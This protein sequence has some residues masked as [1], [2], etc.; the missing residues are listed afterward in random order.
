MILNILL[1][2][3]IRLLFLGTVLIMNS[4]TKSMGQRNNDP[5]KHDTDSL[6]LLVKQCNID[7]CRFRIL[8]DYFWR[9]ANYDVSRARIAGEWAFRVIKDSEN[10]P[11]LADGYDI[12]GFLFEQ[13]KKIDSAMIV[14]HKALDLSI[15]SGYTSRIRWCYYHLGLNHSAAGN[16]D[17]ALYYY[18]ILTQLHAPAISAPSDFEAFRQ[19][20]YLFND[21][22][23]NP[24]SAERYFNQM[25]MVSTMADDPQKMMESQIVL[26]NFYYKTNQTK[27]LLE[28]INRALV[29]AENN[30]HEK[31]LINIYNMI[32]NMFLVNKKNY[33]LALVY[34]KK[35]LD[36][37]RPG[38]KNWEATI[39]NDIGDVYLKMGNDSLA[40]NY[41]NAG[42][43][44]AQ[45]INSK[46]Q[47]SESFRN[48]GKIYRSKGRL[49]E[50]I[51]YFE[52][53]YHTGC[54]KC[55]KVVFHQALIDIADSYMELENYPKATEYYNESL[56]LAREFDA[57]LELAVS[58][59]KLGNYYSHVNPVNAG[60]FYKSAIQFAR[61]SNHLQTIRYIADTLSSYYRK[62]ADYRSAYRYQRLARAMEDSITLIENESNL[63]DW[64]LKFE[65][66]EIHKENRLNE[67]LASA[68]IKKQKI[69]RNGSLLIA[70]LFITLGSVV[71]S[72]Y[73]RKKKDNL[74]LEKMSA[75]LHQA[76]EMKLRFFANV[77][78]EF[79]TPLTLIKAPL[80]YLLSNSYDPKQK[81]YLEIIHKNSNKLIR[82]INQLLNLRKIDE[83]S[84][85]LQLMKGNIAAFIGEI[86]TMFEHVAEKNEVQLQF[87][88]TVT[89][90]ILF[91]PEKIETIIT[92]LLTNAF[93][94]TPKNGSITVNVSVD[95]ALP[96]YI[97]ITIQDTGK[98][99]KKDD[100]NQIFNR[101][102]S[103]SEELNDYSGMNS[104]G[105]GLGLVKELVTIHKGEITV[106]STEGKG[107]CFIITLP[108]HKNAYNHA[109]VLEL[110]P[111]QINAKLY[112]DEGIS[113]DHFS[114]DDTLK[115]E[116]SILVV[117]DN[118]DLRNFL[119]SEISKYAKVY[120]AVN[121]AEGLIMA[122]SELPDMIITDVMMPE[123][124]GIELCKHIKNNINTSHIPVIILS[125]KASVDSQIEGMKTGADDYIPKPFNLSLLLAKIHSVLK[126]RE[127]LR[128][129]YRMQPLIIP[130]EIT[131]TNADETFIST[132]V[133]AVEE[134]ISEPDLS[135][136][137][138]TSV[139]GMSRSVL[140]AKLK[141]IT[142]Q[143]VNEFIRTVKL[144]K[145]SQVLLQNN[146]T[147]SEVAY[148]FGFNTPQYFTKCF[149]EEFGTTP[150]E[151]A[152]KLTNS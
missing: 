102:Y 51:R 89:R 121:G 126:T 110:S 97:R 83:G 53:C 44:V 85:H 26:M 72:G 19:L 57:P 73:R 60:S 43:R 87:K 14:F 32:G 95:K 42:Y 112:P 119:K 50:A 71:Y 92:N 34:Y 94:H 93:K 149:K 150:K 61:R 63:A 8:H 11:R 75:D 108:A 37:C 139:L 27:K 132:L 20:G 114:L 148:M 52:A 127:V 41:V 31:A 142:G 117:E 106:V 24:D 79:R 23:N 15:R 30:N 113:G 18:K 128:Q 123:M 16:Y 39:L 65:I 120:A 76:D 77:S 3:M 5:Y 130:A 96:E 35:V 100:I 9:F 66:E 45:S 21:H 138:L 145:A 103:V 59:L 84:V 80:E 36:I 140:Y 81:E 134:R 125:A 133:K 135:A 69:F 129:H 38:Y 151:F 68:E 49:Q 64:Q 2:T 33:E 55:S 28:A 124:N 147:V 25:L 47:I 78:H 91:D 1:K 74:R 67:Q 105:I 116:Y 141:E 46:H 86:V 54:D 109:E 82:L 122:E 10:L 6:A 4:G 98:G 101:F 111:G 29:L 7:T 70:L 22:Y 152:S 136:S 104:S 143:S 118:N 62:N 137:L 99:I 146:N 88:S 13:S 107:S 40:L 131:V 48:L 115:G 56:Q 12:K 90:N 58:N 17:S 144:K